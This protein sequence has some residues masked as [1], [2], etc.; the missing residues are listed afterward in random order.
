MA[1]S[2]LSVPLNLGLLHPLDVVREAESAYRSGD[3]PLPG[4]EGFVR[5]VL[6]WR[7]YIW[8]LYWRF[9]RGYLG[10]NALGA[11]A[12]LPDWWSELDADAVTV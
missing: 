6:D 12:P 5:Q 8:Q 7:G 4:V 1:H 2:L 10:R 9:G 11:H 3:A